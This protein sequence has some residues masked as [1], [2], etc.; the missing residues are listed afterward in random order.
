[1]CGR[2]TLRSPPEE[3]ADFFGLPELLPTEREALLTPRSNICPT[4]LV[5][6]VRQTDEGRR[7]A[8]LRWGLIP[9]WAQD[10]KIA[11]SLINARSETA[12][13]KPAFRTAFRRRRC[14]VPADGFYEWEKVGRQR[15]PYHIAPRSGGLVAIAG[16]WETWHDPQDVRVETCTLLTTTATEAIQRLHDR[17]PVFLEPASFELWLDPNVEDPDR[18]TPLLVP[19]SL[20]LAI[21]PADPAVFARPAKAKPPTPAGPRQRSLFDDLS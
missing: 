1:M 3:V 6:A 14:L 11:A 9:S 8:F 2:F 5:A 17:M 20:E 12:A 7:L 16:L 10:P 19:S 18:L 21:V 4:E 13:T 15:V